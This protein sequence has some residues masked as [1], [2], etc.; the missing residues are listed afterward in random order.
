MAMGVTATQAPPSGSVMPSGATA[1]KAAAMGPDEEDL[2][3][4]LRAL[5]GDLLAAEALRQRNDQDEED[6]I[7][8]ARFVEAIDEQLRDLMAEADIPL[9]PR[10]AVDPR[11]P[12]GSRHWM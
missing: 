1:C 10:P 9:P 11:V 5:L 4:E 8:V 2:R 6:V 12:T 7:V 3:Q